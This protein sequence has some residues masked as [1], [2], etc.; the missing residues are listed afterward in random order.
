MKHT[1]RAF[2]LGLATATALLTFTYYQTNGK[3]DS[4]A[5]TDQKAITYLENRNYHVLSQTSFEAL[6]ERQTNEQTQRQNSQKEDQIKDKN[7]LDKEKKEK[8]KQYTLTIEPGMLSSSISDELAEADLIE[9]KAEFEI[10][11][12]DNEYSRSIQI[13][14]YMLDN[15]MTYEKIAKRITGQ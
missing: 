11:L 1:I 15:D 6:K 4:K 5:L 14:T 8:V 13:G 2:A 12:K 3:S 9:D 10:F 7:N